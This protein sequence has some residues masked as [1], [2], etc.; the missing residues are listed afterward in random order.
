VA[1]PFFGIASEVIPV[2]SR[3]PMFGYKG[4][5]GATLAI[6]GL[7]MTVWAHHMFTT[8]AVL[9]PFFSFMTF[10]IA[11]PTGV[12]FFN[13]I[14]TMWKGQLTFEPPML[15]TIGFLITFL[16]GGVTGIILA[17]P[18]LNFAVSD[19]YFVVAHFH[20]VMAGTVLFTM[21]AGF[22]FWWPKMTGKMLNSRIGKIQFW[23]MFIGYHMAFL[24]HHW[25]GAEGMP[26]RI[27]NYPDLPGNVTTLNVI[28]SVGSWI[29]ALS[30]LVFL[31]NIY[32]T[33][34]HGVTVT[35]EDPWGYSSS[36]EWATSCPPP[37]H[38]FYRI[39]RIRSERPAFEA[40]YPHIKWGRESRGLDQKIPAT[41]NVRNS[42]GA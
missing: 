29:L 27:A 36:L 18:P 34:R 35:E 2:F 22:Y 1:I 33:W 8:G 30:I 25:L 13:W 11:V 38:N 39:P 32:V 6:A 19:S 42:F 26:R 40:H 3:K 41:S 37:R 10:L 7:S 20:Y 28:S 23:L 16:F 24:V 5:V 9:L 21:F 4:M 14:G 17:S 15:F 12:K 31:W